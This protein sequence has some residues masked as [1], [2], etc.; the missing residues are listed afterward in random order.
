M[1]KKEINDI[2]SNIT[3]PN[4]VNPI[5]HDELVAN[6]KNLSNRLYKDLE[7]LASKIGKNFQECVNDFVKQHSMQKPPGNDESF[8]TEPTPSAILGGALISCSA[9]NSAIENMH[10]DL[11]MD[12]FI[13][14]SYAHG[15]VQTLVNEKKAKSELMRSYANIRFESDPIQLALKE[16]EQSYKTKKTK[17]KIYGFSAQFIREMADKYPVITSQKTIERLVTK[18]NKENDEIPR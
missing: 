10:F 1:D 7:L 5:S 18:L 14:I 9:A 2:Y 13:S 16:I 3:F 8:Y 4:K 11:L 17:F 15:V 6:A 12:I